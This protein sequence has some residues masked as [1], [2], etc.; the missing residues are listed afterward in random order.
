[1]GA[2]TLG[3]VAA[4]DAN[5]SSALLRLTG[6]ELQAASTV[7]TAKQNAI[8]VS[9]VLQGDGQGNISAKTVD[10]AVTAASGNLITSGAVYTAIFGAM[11][12]SY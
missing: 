8:S 4:L 2:S 9:G 6:C 10:T 11:G 5:D 3:S 1:M 7:T 12:G